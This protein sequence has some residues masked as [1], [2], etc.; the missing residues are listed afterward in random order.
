MV[1]RALVFLCINLQPFQWLCQIFPFILD[2]S[3]RNF[4]D[5]IIHNGYDER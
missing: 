3:I 4:V 1:F 2:F 5:A